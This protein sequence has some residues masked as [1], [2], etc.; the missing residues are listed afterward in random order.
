MTRAKFVEELQKVLVE[1]ICENQGKPVVFDFRD[2]DDDDDEWII[3]TILFDNHCIAISTNPRWNGCAFAMNPHNTTICMISQG[4][5][6]IL[7]TFLDKILKA[8]EW[9]N[10]EEQL[11]LEKAPYHVGTFYIKKDLNQ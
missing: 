6:Y 10:L 7:D 2:K 9:D 11:I 1:A 3:A 8:Q 4:W 5:D